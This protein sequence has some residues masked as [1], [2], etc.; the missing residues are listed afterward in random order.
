MVADNL[1]F[2]IKK[3]T[4]NISTIDDKKINANVNL[5]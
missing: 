4:L 1:F 5:K 3:Q 2:D